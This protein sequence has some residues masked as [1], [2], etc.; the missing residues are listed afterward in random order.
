MYL[1]DLPPHRK[2]VPELIR[3][4]VELIKDVRSLVERHC[5]DSPE[6]SVTGRAILR[7]ELN[8]GDNFVLSNRL[9]M[10]PEDDD[11]N[12][13]GHLSAIEV[14]G[15]NSFEMDGDFVSPQKVATK[16]IG[17][18]TYKRNGTNGT[19][20]GAN[21]PRR[22]RR[23]CKTCAPCNSSECGHCAFCLDMVRTI[24]QNLAANPLEQLFFNGVFCMLFFQIKYGG[25]GR[26]KQTCMMRQCLQPML[27]I[28]AQ[29]VYCNLDGWRQQPLSSPQAK[30]MINDSTPSLLMECSVCYEI[31][32]SD[33]AYKAIETDQKPSGIVN[34][35]L[36]NSWEC[37]SCCVSGK[38]TDYKVR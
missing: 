17:T 13:S 3:D 28:T 38:N 37:P 30:Q 5:K 35:D 20:N 10:E 7:L 36:P 24:D 18:R 23:R 21:G 32:H 15:T 6:S 11:A 4:P 33:C 2:N 25:P 29:C 22:R 31:A 26:A 34:E 16:P 12:H 19:S 1:Y 14:S 27:P 8:R 9:K